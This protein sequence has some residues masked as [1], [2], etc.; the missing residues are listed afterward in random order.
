MNGSAET[1]H[2]PLDN[3][4][5]E[6]EEEDEGVERSR[7]RAWERGKAPWVEELKLN[8]AK[9]TSG[10]SPVA[11]TLGQSPPDHAERKLAKPKPDT[12]KL[13][14]KRIIFKYEYLL[15]YGLVPSELSYLSS[16]SFYVSKVNCLCNKSFSV[17]NMRAFWDIVPCNLTGVD[18]R[19]RGVFC[20]HLQEN[21]I[22][23]TFETVCTSE[24]ICLLLQYSMMPY[25]RRDMASCPYK[26]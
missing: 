10:L 23:L 22:T 4:V 20:L 14:L 13:N 6:E 26:R 12:S 17:L 16:A 11:S 24:G 7:G 8:Q 15:C 1:L 21:F 9:K 3:H 25:P 2:T 18:R 19:F 5:V